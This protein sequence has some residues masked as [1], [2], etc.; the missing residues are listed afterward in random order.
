MRTPFFPSPPL[1]ELVLHAHS[2]RSRC[3]TVARV[4]HFRVATV[5]GNIYTPQAIPLPIAANDL[6]IHDATDRGLAHPALSIV[7]AWSFADPHVP[8]MSGL[9][10]RLYTKLMSCRSMAPIKWPPAVLTTPVTSPVDGIRARNA[11]FAR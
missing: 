6:A 4:V 5:Q 9:R 7:I 3:A 2:L 10:R 8:S 11:A 1:N